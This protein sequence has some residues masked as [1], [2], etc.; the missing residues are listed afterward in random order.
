MRPNNDLGRCFHPLCIVF[1]HFYRKRYS[2]LSFFSRSFVWIKLGASMIVVVLQVSKVTQPWAVSLPSCQ[3]CSWLLPILCYLLTQKHHPLCHSP[4]GDSESESVLNLAIPCSSLTEPITNRAG[5][6]SRSTGVQARARD[7]LCEWRYPW[8]KS[9]EK[10][11]K[12]VGAAKHPWARK[13]AL[14]AELG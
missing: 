7:C 1:S 14:S 8:V 9:G 12:K 6:Y 11:A 2:I 13:G 10:D 5:N 4:K 3:A